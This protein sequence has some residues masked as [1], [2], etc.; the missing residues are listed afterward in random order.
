MKRKGRGIQ[1][2]WKIKWARIPFCL[3]ARPTLLSIVA[4]LLLSFIHVHPSYS[5]GIYSYVD[6]NGVYHFTNAPTDPRFSRIEMDE[7]H[8]LLKGKGRSRRGFDYGSNLD[9]QERVERF[10]REIEKAANY[11][12]L[13][14]ALIKAIIRAES[15]G[16][17]LAV[18]SK[19]ALGLMQL[20]PKTARELMVYDPMDPAE[21]IWGG[22]KY[23]SWLMENFDGDIITALAA[24]NSG[25]G[26][27][28]R[29]GGVPPY[30][31]T[32][33]YIRKVLRFWKQARSDS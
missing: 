12:G 16:N 23:L 25:P 31:E 17:P 9:V 6:K 24:Y 26:A 14:P 32:I 27:V 19:G 33:Q 3:C 10:K 13:D 18:S 30:P 11:F 22:S 8:A 21:N 1:I 28:E 5:G 29:Y 4:G 15:G 20:M 7:D 2:Y